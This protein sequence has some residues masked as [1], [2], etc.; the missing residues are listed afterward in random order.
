M[1]FSS[2]RLSLFIIFP[3]NLFRK[4]NKGHLKALHYIIFSIFD[5][6]NDN[7]GDDYQFQPKLPN[8]T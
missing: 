3:N 8:R 6:D 1:D 2:F 7:D 4:L 5:R